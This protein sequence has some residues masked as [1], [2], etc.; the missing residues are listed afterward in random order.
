MPVSPARP[1]TWAKSN[2]ERHRTNAIFLL[3]RFIS[4]EVSEI[5]SSLWGAALL[6]IAYYGPNKMAFDGIRDLDDAGFAQAL[7]Y[8]LADAGVEAMLSVIL[9]GFLYSSLGVRA[10]PTFV[11][12]VKAAKMAVPFACICVFAPVFSLS[13]FLEHFGVGAGFAWVRG[14]DGANST[15][16]S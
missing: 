6:S 1:L 16:L 13:F 11:M 4:A 15:V 2:E 9:G 14:A 3:L 5:L 10:V 7:S 12:Y 8:S